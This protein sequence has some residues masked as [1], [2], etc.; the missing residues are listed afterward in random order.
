MYLDSLPHSKSVS[1]IISYSIAH[2]PL[3]PEPSLS[4]NLS[5]AALVLRVTFLFLCRFG[6]SSSMVIEF[7]PW[8][9]HSQLSSACE[10]REFG[11]TTGRRDF[12]SCQALFR[13]ILSP[14]VGLRLTRY[15]RTRL[16]DLFHERQISIQICI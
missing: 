14:S 1:T 7:C 4:L 8:T 3:V 15:A 16:A 9:S 10:K 11:R 6:Q 12:T 2:K 5:R 13:V